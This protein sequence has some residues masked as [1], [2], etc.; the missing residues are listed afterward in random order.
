MFK[1][2]RQKRKSINKI[3][4]TEQI[5]FII[6]IKLLDWGIKYKIIKNYE[7]KYWIKKWN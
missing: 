7:R 4:D 2:I 6:I 5:V 1:S 3:D